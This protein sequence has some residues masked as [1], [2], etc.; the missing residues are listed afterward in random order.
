M[1]LLAPCEL[2]EDGGLSSFKEQEEE[3][4]AGLGI[5]L[6]FNSTDPIQVKN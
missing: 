1:N 5:L 2:S 4:L 6:S 3:F